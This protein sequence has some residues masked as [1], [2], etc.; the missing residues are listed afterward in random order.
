MALSTNA[1]VRAG[2]G[3]N[4]T[5]SVESLG[6]NGGV[7]GLV[8]VRAGTVTVAR[9]FTLTSGRG[10]RGAQGGNVGPSFLLAVLPPLIGGRHLPTDAQSPDRLSTRGRE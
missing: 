6:G 2:E 4:A 7:A 8:M 1:V 5:T 3:G 9:D 10:G